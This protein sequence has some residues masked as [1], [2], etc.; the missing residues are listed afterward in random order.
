MKIEKRVRGRP[1]I[2]PWDQWFSRRR[3]ILRRGED[4]SCSQSAICQQVRS[5]ASSRGLRVSVADRGE[6][7]EIVIQTEE[8]IRA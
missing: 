4:Y 5:A 6:E 7:V 1:P 3:I 2:Y 8:V